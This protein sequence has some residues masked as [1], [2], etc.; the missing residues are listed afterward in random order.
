[1]HWKTF[2][3]HLIPLLLSFT[4]P[5]TS[6]QTTRITT[7]FTPTCPNPLSSH[8]QNHPA[9]LDLSESFSV[10]LTVRSGVCQGVPV[11]LPLGYIDE[12]D[13]VYLSVSDSGSGSHR[14][15]REEW[16]EESRRLEGKEKE[17]EECKVRLYERPGC[18]GEALV[19]VPFV[20]DEDEY[21]KD[22]KEGT[23]SE[24]VVREFVRMSELWI[25]VDCGLQGSEE[26][27]SHGVAS[28]FVNA[29]ANA[30]GTVAGAGLVRNR[31][32]NSTSM[33]SGRWKKRRLALLGR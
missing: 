33:L 7:T 13:H 15:L 28:I 22:K 1:M 10:G 16:R 29:K 27:V 24:C 4:Q 3:P 30:N 23:E 8:S 17:K 26:D 12:V 19:E 6:L 9:D 5:T 31:T 32:A 20:R 14:E 2:L 25:R 21:V 18:F 11:P